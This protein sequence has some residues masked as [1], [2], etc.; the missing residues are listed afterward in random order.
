MNSHTSQTEAHSQVSP[1]PIPP[2]I[3][4]KYLVPPPLRQARP[5]R[6]GVCLLLNFLT[7]KPGGDGQLFLAD[8]G[9]KFTRK[10]A[11]PTIYE[12]GL[13]LYCR[14]EGSEVEEIS[15]MHR[16]GLTAF[17]FKQ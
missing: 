2:P 7:E 11:Y 4:L 10:P 6:K 14:A 5:V 3:K 13:D 15:P 8:H 1:D 17:V 9:L 16:H 12:F